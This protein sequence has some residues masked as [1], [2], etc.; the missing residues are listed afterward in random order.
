MPDHSRRTR[1]PRDPHAIP[2]TGWKGWDAIPRT[3]TRY[4][5]PVPAGISSPPALGTSSEDRRGPR[6]ERTS[7][8]AFALD[9]NH[10][11]TRVPAK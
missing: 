6:L 7:P 1:S 9:A 4:Y 8:R 5:V 11:E 3:G 10:D 2:G